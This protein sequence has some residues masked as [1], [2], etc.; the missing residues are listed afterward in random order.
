MAKEMITMT[1]RKDPFEG[2]NHDD[3]QRE[4]DELEA[5]IN[6]SIAQIN[7]DFEKGLYPD[8]DAPFKP[9]KVK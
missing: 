4:A 5:E 2:W 9:I 1:K 3:F 6:K 7:A 8:M